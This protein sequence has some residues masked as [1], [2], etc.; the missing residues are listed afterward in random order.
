MNKVMLWDFDGTLGGRIDGEYGRAWSMSML[1]AIHDLFPE[2]HIVVDDIDPLITRDFPWHLHEQDH[3][4]LNTAE[5]WWEYLRSIFIRCY[6]DLGFSQEEAIHLALLAQRHYLDLSKWALYDDSLPVLKQMQLEGWRHIIVSNHAP[7]LEA[8]IEHLGLTT[9]LDAVVNSAV[10]GY[11]KPHRVIFEKALE[12][13]G[14]ADVIWM[15]GDNINADV[16]GAEQLGIKAILVRNMDDR[17]AFQAKDLYEVMRLVE[18]GG[19]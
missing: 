8:I 7:E 15:V 3:L 10:V 19:E 9:L 11:E 12:E 6:T 18:G 5:L 4:H 2:S 14:E 17:A 13:A 1:E 16:F